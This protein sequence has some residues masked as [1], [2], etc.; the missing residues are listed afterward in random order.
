MT[1]DRGGRGTSLKQMVGALGISAAVAAIAYFL[2]RSV[3]QPGTAET[4]V[5]Q[6]NGAN[7]SRS[8]TT[9]VPVQV[10]QA[11]IGECR[12]TRRLERIYVD[13]FLYSA[14]VAD[15]SGGTRITLAGPVDQPQY[16]WIQISEP[17][18]GFILA[19]FLTFCEPSPTPSP[20]PTPTPSPSPSPSPSPTP[21]PGN[22]C[23]IVTQPELSIRR[24]PS[25]LSEIVTF[26]TVNQGFRITGPSRTQTTPSFEQGRIWV[27]IN[28]YGTTGWLA[29]TG[30]NGQGRN[31][32]RVSCSSIGLP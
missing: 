20:S 5:F 4:S 21:T 19:T 22:A 10:A 14:R 32:R 11:A 17:Y 26:I 23:G 15:I 18:R 25:T 6:P 30:P 2:W 31:F 9:D 3:T 27:P 1:Q 8:Q 16:G 28:R 24:Q 12:L 29:E 13:P 7:I